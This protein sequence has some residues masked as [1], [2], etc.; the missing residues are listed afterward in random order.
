MTNP[1]NHE[2]DIDPGLAVHPTN[3]F[4]VKDD[5]IA[6]ENDRVPKNNQNGGNPAQS[7]DER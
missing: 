5:P 4:F 2:E 7:L 1:L 3:E 6:P